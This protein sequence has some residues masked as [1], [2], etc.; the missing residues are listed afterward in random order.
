MSAAPRQAIA[1][2][3]R[4]ARHYPARGSVLAWGRWRSGVEAVG[5]VVLPIA[6][7]LVPA[8]LSG[9]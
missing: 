3:S 2:V 8:R 6:V 9:P 5:G 1:R 4:P 7:R